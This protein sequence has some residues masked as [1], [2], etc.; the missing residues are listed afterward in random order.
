M[1]MYKGKQRQ[2]SAKIVMHRNMY[3]QSNSFKTHPN[4]LCSSDQN[5]MGHKSLCLF[6]NIRDL[7][8]PLNFDNVY[9]VF[10]PYSSPAARA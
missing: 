7:C 4:G 1:V 5:N 2:W 10:T 3:D 9:L 8:R 6:K